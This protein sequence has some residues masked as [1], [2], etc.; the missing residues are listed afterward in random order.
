MTDP[1]LNICVMGNGKKCKK[2]VGRWFRHLQSDRLMA[3][4]RRRRMIELEWWVF[5]R[6]PE[7]VENVSAQNKWTTEMHV[8]LSTKSL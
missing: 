3:K 1:F 8:N 7:I 4:W 5:M 2:I 6:A